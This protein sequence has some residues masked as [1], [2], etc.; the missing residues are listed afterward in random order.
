MR[1]KYTVEYDG[2]IETGDLVVPDDATDT[3][4]EEEVREA[5]MNVVEWEWQK[6]AENGGDSQ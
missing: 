6:C 4:I 2:M 1:I 3:E 5:V